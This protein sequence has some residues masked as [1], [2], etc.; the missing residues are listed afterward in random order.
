MCDDIVCGASVA[1][2]AAVD[3]LVLLVLVGVLQ[4]NVP[5]VQEAGQKSEAAEC[6]V[7]DGVSAADALLDPYYHV[8]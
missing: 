6:D 7:D 1:T 5:G 4:D 8:Y 3:L 2:L